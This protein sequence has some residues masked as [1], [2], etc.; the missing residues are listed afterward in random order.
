MTI[1]FE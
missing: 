1:V